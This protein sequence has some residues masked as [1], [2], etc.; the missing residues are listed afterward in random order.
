MKKNL[1][2]LAFLLGVKVFAQAPAGYYSTATGTGYTLKTQL[3]NII[4]NHDSQSYNALWSLYNHS[5]FK[6]NYYENDG[7][8]LDIYSEKPSNNDSYTYNVGSNDQCGNYS[9]EGDCY[10]REHLIPQSVFN[11][12][13][14]MKTDGHHVVPTDGY[15]NGQRS[16]HP[17]GKVSSASWT[18]TNGSKKGSSAV[19]GYSGTVFEHID[20]FKGDVARVYF[21][22]AT[23]YQ[24][25]ITS[26]NYAMFN[27]TSNQVFKDGFLDILLQWHENDPVS[28]MEV[29][30]NNRVYQFQDN[31]NPFVDNPQYVHDIWGHSSTFST[32]IF[33]PV[34]ISVY[35]NPATEKINIST[36][37]EIQEIILINLNGQ[38]IQQVK[39]PVSQGGV[40]SLDNLSQGF[41]L[42]NVVVENNK[43]T[44]KIIV[45]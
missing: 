36:D 30:R 22:F 24:N 34:S 13:S 8:L 10:N 41:Y 33:E 37:K 2:F 17:I 16:N 6:D 19:P 11:E 40:Y 3:H 20:E 21:Y 1:L 44:K 18:S 38:I 23:R 45:N 39:Q 15:V 32:D 12:A 5:A 27:G 35:P 28:D 9:G 25:Q 14:P 29:A 42:L 43:I 7:T 31:R 26:W 4:K